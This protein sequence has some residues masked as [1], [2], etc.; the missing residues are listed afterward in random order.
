MRA[1]ASPHARFR[2]ALDAGQL[3]Q[4]ETAAQES[5]ALPSRTRF[6]WSYFCS[7]NTIPRFEPAAVKWLGRVLADHQRIRFAD[8][9]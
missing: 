1:D 4:A 8:G 9:R 6:A 7:E 3:A 2:R 5:P